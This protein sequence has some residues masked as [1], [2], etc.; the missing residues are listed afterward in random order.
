MLLLVIPAITSYRILYLVPF[1]APSHWF[2]LKH[3]SDE[4]LR[5]G[6]E[7]TVVTNYRRPESHANLTEI[8]IE[9]PCNINQ[10]CN[11]NMK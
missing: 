10:K 1:P 3:F 6:H 7:V 2:W 4:F 11:L 9:P 5:R 8:I